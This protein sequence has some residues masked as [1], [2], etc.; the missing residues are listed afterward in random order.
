MRYSTKHGVIG[1]SDQVLASA[2]GAAAVSCFG[3]RGMAGRSA[4]DGLVHL[5]RGDKRPLGVTVCREGDRVGLELR[6][7]LDSGVNIRTTC[8][9]LQHQVRYRVQQEC[10]V[11]VGRINIIVET[12]KA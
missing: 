2:A 9:N 6:V 1:I 12:V 11:E 3:V 7:A 4:L 8:A 5:L 10:G